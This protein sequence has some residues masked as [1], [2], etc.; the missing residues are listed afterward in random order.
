MVK[1]DATFFFDFVLTVFYFIF[2]YSCSDFAVSRQEAYLKCS[3]AL[4]KVFQ[5]LDKKERQRKAFEEKVKF[6]SKK[7][8]E[9]EAEIEEMKIEMNCLAA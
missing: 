3:E 2:K 4:H 7:L 5:L 9:Q 1:V 8:H 6:L